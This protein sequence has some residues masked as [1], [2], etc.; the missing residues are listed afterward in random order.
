EAVDGGQ[1][2][3]ERLSRAGRRQHQRVLP[4]GDWRP[5]LGLGRRG[6]LEAP[7]EP[8]GDGRGERTERVGSHP[9][10]LPMKKRGLTPFFQV[11][12][13]RRRGARTPGRRR[14]PPAPHTART[15][16]PPA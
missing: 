12:R 6:P 15:P 5:A 11:S 1:E 13:P 7:P 8:V 2:G 10:S 14:G 4:G 16:T 3:G 9:R